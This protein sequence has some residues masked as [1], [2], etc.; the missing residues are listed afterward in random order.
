M[1]R[2]AT[3]AQEAESLALHTRHAWLLRIN[4]PSAVYRTTT[5]DKTVPYDGEDYTPDGSILKIG[6]INERADGKRGGMPITMAAAN[7]TLRNAV[8]NDDYTW[9]EVKLHLVF[10]NEEHAVVSDTAAVTFAY[11]LD[12]ATI[13]VSSGNSAIVLS[14][15]PYTAKLMRSHGVVAS[16]SEQKARHAGDTFCDFTHAVE[17]V[18]FEWGGYEDSTTRFNAIGKARGSGRTLVRTNRVSISRAPTLAKQS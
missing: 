8:I 1:T 3:S 17:D 18:E 4:F 13:Q 14:C 2:L 6:R 7:D 10:L 12:V 15:E 16:S 11:L 5:A 9:R